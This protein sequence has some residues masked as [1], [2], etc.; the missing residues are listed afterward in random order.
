M[1]PGEVHNAEFW[2]EN[3]LDMK[4][5]IDCLTN[6]VQTK[7]QDDTCKTNAISIGGDVLVHISQLNPLEQI[8]KKS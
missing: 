5:V 7:N 2:H 6:D 4:S 3:G 1:H 8:G